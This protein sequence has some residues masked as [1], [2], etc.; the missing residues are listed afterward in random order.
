MARSSRYLHA[1]LLGVGACGLGVSSVPA[2]GARV[3]GR[4]ASAL[5]AQLAAPP[6]DTRGPSWRLERMRAWVTAVLDHRPGETDAPVRDVRGWR[7]AELEDVTDHVHSVMRLMRVP[8]TTTFVKPADRRRN[9]P[10]R[11]LAYT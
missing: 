4:D 11:S 9:L 8:T 1:V 6:T 2:Q 3:S 10:P 5:V 7:P